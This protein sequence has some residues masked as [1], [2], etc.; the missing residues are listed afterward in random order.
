MGKDPGERKEKETTSLC[1]KE[2]EDHEENK[3]VP[4]AGCTCSLRVFAPELLAEDAAVEP[5][6]AAVS[7][8]AIDNLFLFLAAVLVIFM[9]AGFAM[10][11]SGMNSGKT[12]SIY[13]PK[14][15]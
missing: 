11:E 3:H 10:L 8:Y 7:H 14:T 15:W 6:G 2:V 13:S 1:G 4:A 12:R 9:Q 5:T